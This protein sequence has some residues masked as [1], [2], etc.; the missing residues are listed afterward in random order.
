ME[1]PY[2]NRDGQTYYQRTYLVGGRISARVYRG[3]EYSGVRYYIYVPSYYYRPAF[4]SWAISPWPSPVIYDWGWGPAPWFYGGYFAPAPIYPSAMVWLTDYLIAINLQAAYQ[5]G[6]EAG[7]QSEEPPS[8]RPNSTSQSAISPEVKRVIGNEVKQQLAAEQAAA[9]NP[10]PTST[11][12]HVPDALNPAERVFMVATNLGVA[13]TDRQECKLTPGDIIHRLD[14]TE[15]NDNKVRVSVISSKQGDCSLTAM[16]TLAVNDLQE[17]HNSFQE[18]LDSGLGTLA[19]K[20]GA[21]G[22][23]K[24][25]DTGIT[26][27]EAPPAAPDL[28][29][30]DQLAALQVQADQAEYDAADRAENSADPKDALALFQVLAEK[31]GPTQAQAQVRVQQVT[32]L[33]AN[34]NRSGGIIGIRTNRPTGVVHGPTLMT[35]PAVG[36]AGTHVLSPSPGVGSR[37]AASQPTAPPKSPPPPPK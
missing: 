31:P 25:P 5:A 28:R 7:N 13:A 34:A 21:G 23:P 6:L 32:Q 27:G 20:S 24:A 30:A 33:I 15:G 17:M 2:L 10:P 29:V 3:F 4:Y 18:Q 9:T 22:L 12:A 14:D 37:P 8:S 36:G 11:S 26:S 35:R 1:R 16:P 19:E